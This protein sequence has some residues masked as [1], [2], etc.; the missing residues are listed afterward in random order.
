MTKRKFEQ[1]EFQN[2]NDKEVLYPETK[3]VE[4][5]KIFNQQS[6]DTAET[7]LN[8]D[9]SESSFLKSN[10]TT[11]PKTLQKYLDDIKKDSNSSPSII[12]PRSSVLNKAQVDEV[13]KHFS[14]NTDLDLVQSRIG[15]AILLQSGGSAR[16]C[17][18]NMEVKVFG[19]TIKLAQL[20]ASLK[21]CKHKGRERKLAR[22]IGDD[23]YIICK[24][25]NIVGNLYNKIK[26][27]NPVIFMS[28]PIEIT[29]WLSDFQSDN[30]NC[31]EDCR[32]L[33]NE[34][35]KKNSISPTKK[36]KSTK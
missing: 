20:R 10:Q 21:Y 5:N 11:D 19:K 18:G 12:L 23:I 31:P 9:S 15:I 25:L 28:A 32:N 2:K 24:N 16:G 26:R 4:E 6:Q 29:A 30:K 34:T 17:D 27:D 35:F 33:I 22:A 7:S 14:D 1:N 13:I 8:S 3:V 36:N